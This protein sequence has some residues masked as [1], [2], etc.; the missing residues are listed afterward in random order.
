MQ[1]TKPMII[2]C[3]ALFVFLINADNLLEKA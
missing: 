2:L 1:I 3:I